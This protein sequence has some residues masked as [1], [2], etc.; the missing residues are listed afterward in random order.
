MAFSVSFDR[1]GRDGIN[2][3]FSRG[4]FE[5]TIFQQ[6]PH[7]LSGDSYLLGICFVFDGGWDR[8]KTRGVI[9]LV[10]SAR[11]GYFSVLG[12]ERREK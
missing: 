7:D 4:S 3:H 10:G 5:G 11:V 8:G 6:F 2:E 1:R 12:N 9:F